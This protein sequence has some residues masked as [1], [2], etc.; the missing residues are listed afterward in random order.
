MREPEQR[1]PF[2]VD[3]NCCGRIVK[4]LTEALAN[5]VCYGRW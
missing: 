2:F 3:H 1:L 5:R 4:K